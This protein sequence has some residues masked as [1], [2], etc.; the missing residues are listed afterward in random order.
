[1]RKNFLL[2]ALIVLFMHQ[3][4][5]GQSNYTISGYM[6]DK[7]SG[8]VLI[9]S[10]VLVKELTTGVTTN[11][12]G[13]YSLTL[14]KGKYSLTFTY[15]GYS[16]VEQVVDLNSNMKLNIELADESVEIESVV[17]T[18]KKR[19]E[20][21]TQTQMGVSK[22]DPKSISSMPV[23]MGEADVLKTI[24]LMPGVQAASEGSSGFTVRGGSADQNLILLDEAPVYNASHLLG[25]FSVFNSDAIKNVTLYKG[26]IPASNGGRLSSLMDIRMKDG[27]KKEFHGEGGIGIIASRL[28]LEGPI[29]KD[30]A[31]FIVAGRR[32]YADLFLP[33]SSDSTV[34]KNKL[35]FYDLNAKVN[36][37]IDPNNR[38]YLSG[39]FGRDFFGY[40]KDL[41]FGWGNSTLTARWN[42]LYS[43]KLF[44]NLT[45]LYSNYQYELEQTRS[46]P[47]F[48]WTAK[49]ENYSAKYDLTYYQTTNSTIRYGAQIIYH[50]IQP[51]RVEVSNQEDDYKVPNSYALEYAAYFQHEQKFNKN[52]SVNYGL[53]ASMFQNMG[54]TTVFEVDD[55]EV[56]DT[57]KY[58]KNK[59][60]NTYYGLEPRVSGTYLLNSVSSVKA[61][62]SRTIQYLQ[63]AS[64]S[65]GGSPL[66]VW[67]T[68]SKYVKPQYSD[69]F[70]LGY[71][72]NFKDDAY[73]FS[74]EGFYKQMHNQI[75]F[76]D[77][78]ELLLNNQME[79]ELRF[80][81]AKAYGIELLLR[82]NDGKLTGW[83]GYTFSKTLRSFP[84][85]NDGKD[86]PSNYD[87]PHN[88]NVVLNYSISPRVIISGAWVFTSGE[89]ATY[90]TMR[91]FH[92]GTNL[93]MYGDK[94]G[95][96][97]P[98]Y[99]RLDVSLTIKNKK[100][101]GR[102]WESEWNI[103]AY[104]AYNRSNAYSVYFEQDENNPNKITAYKMVMFKI[105]PSITYNFKF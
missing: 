51:G 67:F 8:E 81:K 39:Y 104:N 49:Q 27:N 88:L 46:Q 1:M 34:R 5:F 3:A 55:F 7:K 26:D 9:G 83:I 61:A 40:G 72:R 73:E 25:F 100:K 24:Q 30:K 36:Y 42:H 94:N 32:T 43:S 95:N 101:V 47:N 48:K 11:Q 66:D 92:A 6:K 29:V 103:A 2:L 14:P 91:F 71:F 20:N 31:S 97:L 44:S 53:R 87:K 37:E 28:A 65:T 80:G 62:Y 22:I 18:S 4:G 99:H 70:G 52:F 76:A 50:Y 60:Y 45:F 77:G 68:A 75:D 96:R 84:D 41:S 98:S 10:T 12:Y 15:I 57:V 74:V 13:F 89:A 17:V 69:Q 79:K 35:Y 23:L 78:A 102:R 33:L 85:I 86:Y 93:P 54:K 16:K 63:R 105:V 90:P 19:N 38:I 21:I 58:G 82:K 59:I 64:N 56:V